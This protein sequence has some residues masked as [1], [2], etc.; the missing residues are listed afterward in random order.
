MCVEGRLDYTLYFRELL[1]PSSRY[2]G[3]RGLD[4]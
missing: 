1:N 3:G 4:G 2:L